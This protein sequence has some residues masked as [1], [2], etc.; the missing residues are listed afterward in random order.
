MAAQRADLPVNEITV[1]FGACAAGYIVTRNSQ[2][3]SSG[4]ISKM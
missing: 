4:G 2:H 3:C 1:I